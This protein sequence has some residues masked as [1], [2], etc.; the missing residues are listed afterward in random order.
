MGWHSNAFSRR[1]LVPAMLVLACRGPA[2]GM[3]SG[4]DAGTDSGTGAEGGGESETDSGAS[5][6]DV[7]PDWCGVWYELESTRPTLMMVV[8]RSAATASHT[9]DHDEDTQTPEVT[10]WWS[11]RTLIEDIFDAAADDTLCGPIY[12]P[13]LV[14]SPS[15]QAEPIPGS[16][17]CST[18]DAYEVEPWVLTESAILAALPDAWSQDLA[19]ASPLAGA[20]QIA[21]DEL[22]A[23]DEGLGLYIMLFVH[24]PPTCAANA[25]DPQARFEQLD[26]AL[27]ELIESAFTEEGIGTL[28]VAIDAADEPYPDLEDGLA[29]GVNPRS[30]FNQLATAGGYPAQDDPDQR[31]YTPDDV[32]HL[33]DPMFA[34]CSC[35][36]W[37]PL[38]DPEG[39]PPPLDPDEIEVEVDDHPLPHLDPSACS[40]SGESGWTYTDP[41][42]GLTLCGPACDGFDKNCYP[43]APH[44]RM[45]VVVSWDCP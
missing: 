17:A 5:T 28:V 12:K 36:C 14:V 20:Y 18:L 30:Y 41:G 19:G 6:P 21:V 31:F 1:W 4:G 16:G 13:G 26:P 33:A 8:D 23:L 40:G 24:A 22:L 7:A 32:E 37:V 9:W 29:D 11:I 34:A 38:Q 25:A 15:A 35:G 3:D 2:T 10:A 45:K 39:G 27:L 44:T 42:S 43:E